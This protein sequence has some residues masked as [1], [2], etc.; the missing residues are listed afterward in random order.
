VWKATKE[1]KLYAIEHG[2][3]E[4]IDDNTAAPEEVADE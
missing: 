1:G 4:L 2:L 3:I